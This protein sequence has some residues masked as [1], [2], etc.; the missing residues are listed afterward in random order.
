M[1]ITEK[2]NNKTKSLQHERQYVK[3]NNLNFVLEIFSND[4]ILV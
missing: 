4:F 3:L 1:Y 2:I